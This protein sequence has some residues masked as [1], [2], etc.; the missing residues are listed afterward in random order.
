MFVESLMN[1]R[2]VMQV[3]MVD[4]YTFRLNGMDTQS[5]PTSAKPP[6][7]FLQHRTSSIKL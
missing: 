1:A 3:G 6:A 2:K 5:F 4:T 7:P